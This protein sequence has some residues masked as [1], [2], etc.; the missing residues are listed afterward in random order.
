MRQEK[1]PAK[2]ALITMAVKRTIGVHGDMMEMSGIIIM[3]MKTMVAIT[4]GM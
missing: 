3:T 4:W 2:E 1:P